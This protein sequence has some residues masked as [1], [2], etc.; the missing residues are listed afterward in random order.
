MTA[1]RG[2]SRASAER[3][4]GRKTHEQRTGEARP[5]GYGD[6]TQIAEL[7]A[8]IADRLVDYGENPLQVRSRSDL[9]HDAAESLVKLILRGDD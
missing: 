1:T 4:R 3:L 9:R 7:Q 8:R 2:I 5:I 6:G